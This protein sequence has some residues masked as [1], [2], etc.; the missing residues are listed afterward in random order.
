[1]INFIILKDIMWKTYKEMNDWEKMECR[2]GRYMISKIENGKI[3]Y[4][5]DI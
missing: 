1:M 2:L 5:I 4:R 3:Y